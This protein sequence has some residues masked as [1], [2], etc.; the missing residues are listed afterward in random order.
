M[1]KWPIGK[2]KHIKIKPRIY[3]LFVFDL[4]GQCK[5][6]KNKNIIVIKEICSWLS[7]SLGEWEEILF[8]DTRNLEIV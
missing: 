5:F 3:V 2:G 8:T 1:W 7:P 4:D 6:I